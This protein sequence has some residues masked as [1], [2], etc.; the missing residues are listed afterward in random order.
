MTR[1][2]IQSSNYDMI[3]GH[4]SVLSTF[5]GPYVKVTQLSYYY[6]IKT[7]ARGIVAH[8]TV[9]TWYT[10]RYHIVHTT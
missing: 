10:L 3:L 9:I 7:V 5:T 4:N 2:M 1:S 8:G 6:Q